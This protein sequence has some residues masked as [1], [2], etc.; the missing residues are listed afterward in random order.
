MILWKKAAE[1]IFDFHLEF[2]KK[3]PLETVLDKTD[4]LLIGFQLSYRR[5][6]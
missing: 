6:G 5:K 1:I 3:S 4:T 2:M